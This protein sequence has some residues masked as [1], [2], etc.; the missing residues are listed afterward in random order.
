MLC[1]SKLKKKFEEI[2]GNLTNFLITKTSIELTTRI[3]KEETI[4]N[5]DKRGSKSRLDDRLFLTSSYN[6]I[7]F[8]KSSKPTHKK[9][10]K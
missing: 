6:F 5:P 7:D 1:F 10:Q 8:K 4:D 2:K 3:I 9:F